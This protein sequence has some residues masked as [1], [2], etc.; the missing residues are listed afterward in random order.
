MTTK[1]KGE[2]DKR[3]IVVLLNE[4]EFAL[5]R[6]KT[7]ATGAPMSEVIRRALKAYVKEK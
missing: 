7:E 1:L 4:E 5:L 3:R 6:R 2:T